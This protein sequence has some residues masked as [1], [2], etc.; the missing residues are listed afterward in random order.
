MILAFIVSII[1]NQDLTPGL[2]RPLSVETICATKWGLDRRFVT[3]AMK[4]HIAA[5]YGIPWTNRSCCEFDH[6]IPRSLGGADDILNLW[7]QS[8]ADAKQKDHLEIILGNLVCAK[9]LSL[10]GAQR[11]IAKDWRAAYQIYVK[12]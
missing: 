10:Y 11:A 7:P 12:P 6:L 9:K 5:A 1:L 3:T 4:R 2:I 8:W